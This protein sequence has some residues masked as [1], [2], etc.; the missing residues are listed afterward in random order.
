MDVE[1]A[2]EA[3]TQVKK[4]IAEKDQAILQLEALADMGDE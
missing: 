3:I 1:R 4:L 2:K